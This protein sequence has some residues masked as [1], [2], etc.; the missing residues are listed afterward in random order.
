LQVTVPLPEKG[1]TCEDG[2]VPPSPLEHAVARIGDRWTLLVVDALLTGPRRFSDLAAEL[3]GAAS[4][5]T[6]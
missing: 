1:A 2:A 6:C 3:G 4:R 5:P